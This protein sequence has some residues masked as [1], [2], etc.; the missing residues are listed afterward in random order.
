MVGIVQKQTLVFERIK[1]HCAGSARNFY[2]EVESTALIRKRQFDFS[3]KWRFYVRLC[4]TMKRTSTKGNSGARWV[5]QGH[6]WRRI[7][8][9]VRTDMGA[10]YLWL[11]H[12][13]K[14]K[15][16]RNW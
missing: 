13:R 6:K 10:V 16:A 11:I 1:K 7:A 4:D 8:M 5:D 14:A 15:Q 9:G 3:P 12:F 2:P